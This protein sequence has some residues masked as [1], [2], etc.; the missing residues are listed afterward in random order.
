M[1]PEAVGHGQVVDDAEAERAGVGRQGDHGPGQRGEVEG[2]AGGEHDRGGGLLLGGDATGGERDDRA[3]DVEVAARDQHR[4]I[5][6]ADRDAG[7]DLGDLVQRVLDAAARH[8]AGRGADGVAVAIDVPVVAGGV[9]REQVAGDEPGVA[10][11]HRVAQ[12]AGRRQ[13]GQIADAAR[14][15]EAD[16]QHAGLID[17]GADQAAA[18]VADEVVD[19]EIVGRDRELGAAG[20]RAADGADLL[21]RG[22]GEDGRGLGRG[23][24]LEDAGAGEALL[25]LAPQIGAHARPGEQ[26]DRVVLLGDRRRRRD[27]RAAHLVG[28]V[29]DGD[30]VAADLAPEDVGVEAARADRLGGEG[31]AGTTD[32]GAGDRDQHAGR[33]MERQAAVDGVARRERAGGGGAEGRHR[34]APVGDPAGAPA[35]G[36]AGDEDHGQ[37][38]G[39]AGIGAIPAG[40]GDLLGIDLLEIDRAGGERAP[41]MGAAED[42]EAAGERG[43]DRGGGVGIGQREVGLADLERAPQRRRRG[44]GG[45]EDGDGAEA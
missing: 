20:Q 2:G 42:E 24:E 6:H 35:V 9:D 18:G 22:V 45:E 23:V 34:P 8:R 28:V 12:D 4:G 33:V 14:G 5:G 43:A 13:V 10:G 27:Q 1:G 16:D 37:V 17:A 41:L 38:A 36:A 39:A 21:A 29:D 3:A 30:A 19:V 44:V 7:A 25:E 31:E 32:D 11:R 40:Q 15:V 26:A